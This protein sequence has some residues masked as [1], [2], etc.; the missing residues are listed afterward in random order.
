MRDL[1]LRQHVAYLGMTAAIYELEKLGFNVHPNGYHDHA[2]LIIN[3]HL[4]VE[5]KASLWTSH[6]TRA[7]RYQFNTRQHPNLYILYCLGHNRTAFVI[8][9]KAIG[10]RRNIAIWSQDPED[11]N[12][13]WAKYRQAWHIIERILEQ[14]LPT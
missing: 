12:G 7:G 8:P 13:Q 6:K 10:N 9:G 11:Y 3:D 2:D 4:R 5:V 14:C 1:D